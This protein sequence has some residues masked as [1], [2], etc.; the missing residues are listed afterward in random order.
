MD[1]TLGCDPTNQPQLLPVSAAG[2][3]R[4]GVFAKTELP[5]GVLVLPDGV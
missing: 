1:G 5:I 2:E 4:P 3:S